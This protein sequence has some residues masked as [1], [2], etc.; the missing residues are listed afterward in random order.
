MEGKKEKAVIQV[1]DFGVQMTGFNSSLCSLWPW[2]NQLHSPSLSYL[3][4]DMHKR[5]RISSAG[6]ADGIQWHSASHSSAHAGKTGTPQAATATELEPHLAPDSKTGTGDPD[7]TK[8]QG[9]L[10]ILIMCLH[11]PYLSG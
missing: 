2:E 6:A 11:K 10:S 8:T 3:S 7:V 4:Y 5:P 9:L 1:A